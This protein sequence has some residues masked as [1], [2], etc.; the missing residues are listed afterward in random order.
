MINYYE[1]I[2]E[3]NF[4]SAI[5]ELERKYPRIAELKTTISFI[6]GKNPQIAG[7]EIHGWKGYYVAR[8]DEPLISKVPQID[9]IYY[10]SESKKQ[11]Y[12][13]FLRVVKEL[14]NS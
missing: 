2:E 9:I 8:T 6:L 7:R 14:N 3:Q 4:T 13:I 5:D 11:V 1:I 12:L 10:I